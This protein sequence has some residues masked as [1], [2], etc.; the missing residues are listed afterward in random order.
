MNIVCNHVIGLKAKLNKDMLQEVK[1]EN[2]VVDFV[3]WCH[4]N[5]VTKS[6]AA[7]MRRNKKGLYH[8]ARQCAV[9]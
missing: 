6:M 7:H 2:T 1:A 5:L 9:S 8:S 4:D 3:R